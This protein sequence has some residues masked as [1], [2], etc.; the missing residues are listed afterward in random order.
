MTCDGEL[1]KSQVV[2]KER[3]LRKAL[4]EVKALLVVSAGAAKAAGFQ[5]ASFW[6]AYRVARSAASRER[7]R[8]REIAL[9]SAIQ[10]G[11]REGTKV[12]PSNGLRGT[13]TKINRTRVRV[14][15]ETR[16]MRNVPPR[17]MKKA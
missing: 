14:M 15:T 1:P 2:A 8:S 7:T 17:C 3:E 4:E 10:E 9:N 12:I 11:F 16:G 5:D 6:D 13:I